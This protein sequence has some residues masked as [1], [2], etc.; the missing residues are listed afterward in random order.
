MVLTQALS[1]L[2]MSPDVSEAPSDKGMRQAP[3]LLEKPSFFLFHRFLTAPP[4]PPRPAT[5]YRNA[6]SGVASHARKF[7]AEN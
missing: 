3:L 5:H 2:K 6:R 7:N 4:L 1:F